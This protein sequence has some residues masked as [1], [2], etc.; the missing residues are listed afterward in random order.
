MGGIM[1]GNLNIEEISQIIEHTSQKLSDKVINRRMK[2]DNTVV[3]REEDITSKLEE[4]LSDDLNEQISKDLNEYSGEIVFEVYPFKKTEEKYVGADLCGIVDFNHNGKRVVKYFLAQSKV[5]SVKKSK[6]GK[7]YKGGD[8]NLSGQVQDMLNITSDSFVF[9][10]SDEGIFVTPAL[11]IKLSDG[12][13]DTRNQYYK[14]LG[15][16]YAE[17]FKCFVG[18]HL[19]NGKDLSTLSLDDIINLVKSKSK[20]IHYIKIGADTI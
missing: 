10:Y 8:S 14:S 7:Y 13:I 1:K 15:H 20:F 17:F 5:C 12:K 16:F 18:D 3:G 19:V 9:I 11:G 6:K 4:K 2:I